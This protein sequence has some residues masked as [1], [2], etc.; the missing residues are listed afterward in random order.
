LLQQQLSNGD[1]SS[2]FTGRLLIGLS[3][4]GRR[5][6]AKREKENGLHPSE[7][8]PFRTFSGVIVGSLRWEPT[9]KR[10]LF[11]RGKQCA[12]GKQCTDSNHQN[13]SLI[14]F[15]ITTITENHHLFD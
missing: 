1:L 9:K 2:K 11:S 10:S 12:G 13:Q 5:R 7:V 4:A 14:K 3:T 8:F 15:T 6:K